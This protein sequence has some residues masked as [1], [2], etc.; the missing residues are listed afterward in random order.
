METTDG[1]ASRITGSFLCGW[2]HRSGVIL[3]KE[4]VPDPKP[5]RWVESG[6]ARDFVF[7]EFLPI[8]IVIMLWGKEFNNKAMCSW[9]D[10]QAIVHVVNTQSSSCT[11]VMQVV[12]SFVLHCLTFY[13]VFMFPGSIAK[14]QILSLGSSSTGFEHWFQDHTTPQQSC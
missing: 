3:E 14:W 8:L 7:L 13:I 6:I 11:L 9:C 4:T 5:N 2:G 10:N 1:P 12:Q